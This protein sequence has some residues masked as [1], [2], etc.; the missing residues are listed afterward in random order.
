MIAEQANAVSAVSYESWYKQNVSQTEGI[1]I[2]DGFSD[3]FYMKP[4][5]MTSDLRRAI[6]S[7]F[8]YVVQKGKC[9]KIKILKNRTE[10]ENAE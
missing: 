9:V 1:W 7:D 8:G 5:Q 2:G 10:D 4:S 6:G 3:Q